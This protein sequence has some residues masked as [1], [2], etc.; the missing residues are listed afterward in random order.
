MHLPLD[1]ATVKGFL[2]PEEGEALYDHARSAPG[3]APCLEIGSYCGKSTLYLGAACQARGAVLFAVDHHR[4]S[5]EHQ[6][7][8][9]YHDPALATADGCGVD[10]FGVFRRTL[11]EADLED[12][13]VPIVAPSALAARAWS[14][15]LALVF[16]DGGHSMDAALTDYRCWAPRL[17]TGGILAIHDIFPDPADGGR[18]PFEIWQLARASGLFEELAMVKTLGLLR[19]LG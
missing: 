12:T 18:P 10:S 14:T 17:M 16:I 4:G 5:E 9:A 11:R 6:P 2:D 15:P 3:V 13:V 8:E 7:G 1:P 19:R